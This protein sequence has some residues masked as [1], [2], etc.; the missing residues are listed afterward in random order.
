[1]KKIS[2]LPSF[3]I[4]NEL[5]LN[6]SKFIIQKDS[7]YTNISTRS[8]RQKSESDNYIQYNLTNLNNLNNL[9]QSQSN[10]LIKTPQE[11]FNMSKLYHKYLTSVKIKM[12]NSS[13]IDNEKTKDFI[14]YYINA[15]IIYEDIRKD[16]FWISNGESLQPFYKK[17]IDDFDVHKMNL[18]NN[19][20]MLET[21][22][23]IYG[24]DTWLIK[25]KLKNLNSSSNSS[26]PPT[27][28]ELSDSSLRCAENNI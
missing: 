28:Y 21:I 24:F 2:L 7:K 23:K 10:I 14:E 27:N 17:N 25:N 8:S 1:M 13:N 5:R 26:S 15:N 4:S 12:S 16:W 19:Y 9:N 20:N 6:R 18:L 3:D 22:A 11:M